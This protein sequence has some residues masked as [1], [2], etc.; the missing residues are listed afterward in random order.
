MPPK[1]TTDRSENSSYLIEDPEK[2]AHNLLQLL[3]D[4]SSAMSGVLKQTASDSGPFSQTSELRDAAKSMN[5]IM[6]H[7]LVD[8]GKLA[9]AQSEL[10]GN[11]VDLWNNSVRRMFGEEVE[12]IA[13]PSPGDNRFKD[14][15]WSSNPYFDF[16]KQAYLLTTNWAEQLVSNTEGIDERTKRKADF[17]LRQVSSALSPSNFP[18]TNPEIIRETLASNGNNLIEGLHNLVGDMNSSD[19]L[20]KVSQTDISAFEVGKNLATTPGKVIFQNEV[21]QLLQY[22]PSTKDV[23]EIPLLIVPPWINKFYILDLTEQK[24]FIKY[25]VAQGFTVF[26]VSWVNPDASLAKESFED[27]MKDGILAATKAVKQETGVKKI[28]ILGYCVG[29]TLLAATLAHQ[30]AKRRAPFSSAT[31]LTTQVDFTHAGDLLLF[32]DDEQLESLHELMSER[33]YLDGSRMANAF[34][35]LRPRDLIWPYIVNNY[36]LGKKPMPFDL[37]YWNQDSTRMPAANHEFYLREFYHLNKLAK[38]EMSLGGVK[39]DMSKVKI[40]IYELAAKDDHIAPPNSV[41]LGAKLFG[42]PVEFVLSGS[43]HIAGVVNPPAKKKYQYWTQRKLTEDLESWRESAKEHPGSW[44]PHW[45][46]WLRKHSGPKV[47]ARKPG[48]NLGVIENAPGSYVR[49]KS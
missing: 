30:A 14:P 44:W 12:A 37:L 20:M 26:V 41:F 17:Y 9:E 13:E 39:L 48:A 31:F 22:K 45:I 40:P 16:W 36:M 43:G 7:W 15:E 35:M 18:A 19:D 6:Q 27:Y 33:G 28:N 10:L 38:G 21:F 25:V 5:E 42:G 46:K 24:S 3:E 29:G 2:F 4:S 1:K 32:V 49:T 47:P 8:P 11:Y 23:H 34:N